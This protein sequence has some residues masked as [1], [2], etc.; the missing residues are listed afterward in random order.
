VHRYLARKPVGFDFR[1]HGRQLLVIASVLIFSIVYSLVLRDPFLNTVIQVTTG[2]SYKVNPR[3]AEF[4]AFFQYKVFFYLFV[5]YFLFYIYLDSPE[6]LEKIKR[7]FLAAIVA[8]LVLGF[9][10]LLLYPEK[11]LKMVPLFYHSPSSWLFAL[12]IF[13]FILKWSFGSLRS[14]PLLMSG[15]VSV[16]FMLFILLSFRR[17]M[18]AAIFISAITLLFFMPG[19]YRIKLLVAACGIGL[20]VGAAIMISPLGDKLLGAVSSRLS[21]T[22]VSDTSTLYRLALFVY[23]YEHFTELPILGYGVE[24][25]WNKIVSLGYFRI[26][27]ENI[28]SIYFWLLLRTGVLGFLMVL[29]AY[30][31]MLVKLLGSVRNEDNADRK[32]ILICVFLALMMY[33]FSGIFNP[34]YSEARYMIVL[35]LGLAM[36]SRIIQF[37]RD[38]RL[39]S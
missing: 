38:S 24:P 17:T 6:K 31:A 20:L 23:F 35:G 18:W 11:I 36:A 27:L 16:I 30:M 5:S 21:Q 8:F 25:L 19:R 3:G 37:S 10:R 9:Y 29:T 1:G 12:I 26:N 22:S 32:A 34:V 14:R 39:A 4:I 28:H 15:I 2:T 33:L 13:Y 7:I